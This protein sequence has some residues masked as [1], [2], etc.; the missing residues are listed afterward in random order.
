[1]PYASNAQRRKFHELLEQGKIKPEVVA[2]FDA[3]SK[4]LK[5][6][7]HVGKAANPKTDAMRFFRRR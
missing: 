7:D 2:E 3:A 6:P 4:G 5:L 1:M